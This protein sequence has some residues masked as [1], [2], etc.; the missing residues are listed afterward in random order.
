MQL[1]FEIVAGVKRSNKMDKGRN[2]GYDVLHDHEFFMNLF[3]LCVCHVDYL[4]YCIIWVSKNVIADLFKQL[5]DRLGRERSVP[6]RQRWESPWNRRERPSCPRRPQTIAGHPPQRANS[7]PRPD[8]HIQQQ[9]DR[10]HQ[11]APTNGTTVA[12]VA[13]VTSTMTFLF[14]SV[15]KDYDRC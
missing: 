7:R 14:H 15:F 1:Y 5:G 8:K 12:S 10:C 3:E 6:N 9:T 11:K 2:T 13:D 4:Q